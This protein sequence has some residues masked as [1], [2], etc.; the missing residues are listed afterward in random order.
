MVEK[1]QAINEKLLEKDI[2]EISY[3]VSSDFGKVM[4]GYSSVSVVEVIFGATV[5]MCS[6]IN[7]FAKNN[8]LIIGNNFHNVA[9]ML[10]NFEFKE[11]K[12]NPRIGLE[13]KYPIFQ[14]QR[15]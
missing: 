5:N 14:V 13:N 2:P 4:V 9:K 1:R 8:R 10:G 12:N 6:K 7:P 3:K 11:I 15:S